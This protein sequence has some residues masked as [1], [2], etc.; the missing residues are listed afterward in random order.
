MNAFEKTLFIYYTIL[1]LSEECMLENTVFLV[2]KKELRI[3][4]YL[5]YITG[6]KH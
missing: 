4:M 1:M 3:E 2:Q 5:K 6:F